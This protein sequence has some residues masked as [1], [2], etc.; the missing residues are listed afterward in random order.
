MRSTYC[1]LHYV[2]YKRRMS[3]LLLIPF[4][5]PLLLPTNN[6]KIPRF[7][8]KIKSLIS[9]WYIFT[10]EICVVHEVIIG[11]RAKN[12]TLHT[13]V[14]FGDWRFFTTT[15]GSIV[16]SFFAASGSFFSES[17]FFSFFDFLPFSF[18]SLFKDLMSDF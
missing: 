16:S 3:T 17:S 5:Y 13:T 8:N 12:L 18:F 9:L 14:R 6:Q 10:R 4:Y 7:K 1:L 11:K 2:M 15:T